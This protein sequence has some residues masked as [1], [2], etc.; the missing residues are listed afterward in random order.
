[1]TEITLNSNIISSKKQMVKFLD[2]K[3]I[4]LHDKLPITL[5]I[6]DN[7]IKI[8]KNEIMISH[9][10]GCHGLKNPIDDLSIADYKETI[11]DFF[12]PFE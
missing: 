4:L 8:N 5:I 2:D 7:R 3:L 12:F 9:P 11:L 10:H 1:M 6:G